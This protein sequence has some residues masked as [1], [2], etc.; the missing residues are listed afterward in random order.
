KEE[1]ETWPDGRETWVT[2]TKLPLRDR[3]GNIIGTF[4]LSRDITRRKLAE[5]RLSE[6]ERRYRQVTEASLDAIIVADAGQ[7]ITL[8][9]PAAERLFGYQAAEVLGQPLSVLLPPE[10]QE[11][12]L[13]GGLSSSG[14]SAAKVI[15]RTV[16]IRGRRKDG[17]EFPVEFSMNVM[18]LRGERQY[19]VSIRDLT[20][21]NR[22]RAAMVQSEKLASIGLL[23][24][25]IAHEINN[26]MAYVSNNLVVLERDTTGLLEILKVYESTHDRLA[27]VDPAA[28]EQV[29]ALAE[30]IDLDYVR[31][32][33][34]RLLAQTR[35]GAR[36]VTRIV[37]SMRGLARSGPPE[38]ET[39]RL[40]DLFD[41]SLDMI[42]G[43]LHRAGIQVATTYEVV[44]ARCVAHQLSQVFLNLL[45]NALQAIQTK[46][47]PQGGEIRIATRAANDEVLIE[48]ADN[49]CGIRP[50]HLAHLFDP[51][52][53][54]KPVGEGTG[55]GLWISHNI[56]TGHGGRLE[57][58]SRVGEGSVFRIFLP[59]DGRAE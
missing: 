21:R 27:Q 57:A 4:G 13:K 29:Q 55:L 49:G 53:T 14:S 9:N 39:A 32:N 18:E 33:L 46:G 51:F 40:P 44:E 56:V 38:L 25:G 20:E 31:G 26:P 12:H 15:A 23:S 52:F 50:E 16:E 6:S 1:K 41:A 30:K 19:L 10:F 43:R 59:R 35:E 36:R 2:T 37:Q 17:A 24:A 58:D 3:E 54:T 45:V 48:V 34:S 8:F 11:K 5:R 28:L 42:R 7:H 22:L 47:Q